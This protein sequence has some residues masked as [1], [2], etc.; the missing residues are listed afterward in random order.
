MINNNAGVDKDDV[1]VIIEGRISQHKARNVLLLNDTH[2]YYDGVPLYENMFSDVDAMNIFSN[3]RQYNPLSPGQAILLTIKRSRTD[4]M[5][6]ILCFIIVCTF[7]IHLSSC[8][9]FLLPKKQMII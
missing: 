5:V 2:Y 8:Y 4:R 9:I 6:C 3:E 1:N 7:F